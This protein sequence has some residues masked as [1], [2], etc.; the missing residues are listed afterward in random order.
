ME[1]I[2]DLHR[3]DSIEEKLSLADKVRSI[4]FI[5]V[6]LT[7]EE[8]HHIVRS[9]SYKRKGKDRFRRASQ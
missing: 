9:L 2:G 8:F 7:R 5:T 6:S 1:H 3:S 4:R